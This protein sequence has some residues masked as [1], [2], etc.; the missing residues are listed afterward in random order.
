MNSKVKM[1]IGGYHV[2][3]EQ[4]SIGRKLLIFG[5]ELTKQFTISFNSQKRRY[6]PATLVDGDIE[7]QEKVSIKRD[8]AWKS[9][10]T[11]VSDKFSLI[12]SFSDEEIKSIYKVFG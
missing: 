9:G 4:E 10:V 3:F 5:E 8:N 1:T 6:F 12:Y 11:L 7:T 2:I